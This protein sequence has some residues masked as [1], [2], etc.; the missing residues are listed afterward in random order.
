MTLTPSF[1]AGAQLAIAAATPFI[2]AFVAVWVA[3]FSAQER[4][5]VF[6]SYGWSGQKELSFVGVH[7]RSPQTIWI[8]DI[9]F[10]R[11]TGLRWRR[12]EYV[13]IDY[14]DP[15]DLAFP[16]DVAPG[17]TRRLVLDDEHAIRYAQGCGRLATFVARRFRR[18]RFAVECTTTSG[19][20]V[21]TPGEKMLPYKE[22]YAGARAEG[23]W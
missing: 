7:N 11:R 14:D 1:I 23:D 18:D 10:V 6:I 4:L 22:Q 15:T 5:S 21:R 16:Y 17:A 9:R 3:N 8:I 12:D 2:A 13:A 20:R 19:K